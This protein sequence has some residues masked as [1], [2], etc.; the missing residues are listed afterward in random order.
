[1]DCKTCKEHKQSA[2]PVPY[3]LHESA[4]AR[5][6]RIIKRLWIALILCII[7]LF[8]MFV[9]E[10]QFVDESWTYEASTDNGGTAVANGD[11]EVYLYGESE[12]NPANQNP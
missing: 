8:G 2:E 10:A 11:G 9:Y 6:E 4:M 1:M 12:S 3:I 5:Q 7:G